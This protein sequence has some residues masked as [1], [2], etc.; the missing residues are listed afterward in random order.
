MRTPSHKVLSHRL[1]TAADHAR[2]GD[3][4]VIV[5]EKL[6][7]VGQMIV[8]LE[9]SKS[10]VDLVQV[11]RRNGGQQLRFRGGGRI[12]FAPASNPDSLRGW[13]QVDLFL[14]D[15][16]VATSTA[17]EQNM[18]LACRRDPQR[19]AIVTATVVRPGDSLTIGGQVR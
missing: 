2:K 13:A 12:R 15:P 19:Y 7:H 1:A 5:V 16:R 4:V 3:E 18:M 11:D 8:E 9:A 17:L 14:V 10:A 6:D